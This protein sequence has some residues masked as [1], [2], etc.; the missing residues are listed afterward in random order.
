MFTSKIQSAK[1]R[2]FVS[3]RRADNRALVERIRD[4]LTERYRYDVFLDVLDID[5]GEDWKARI[6]E[7][8][9]SSNVF[10]IMIGEHWLDRVSGGQYRLDSEDDPVAFEIETALARRSEMLIIPILLDGAEI[11]DNKLWPNKLRDVLNFHVMRINGHPEFKGNIEN[12][13]TNI[14][15]HFYSPKPIL[16]IAIG[17]LVIVAIAIIIILLLLSQRTRSIV[18]NFENGI[19]EWKCQLT[20]PTTEA[21]VSVKQSNEYAFG[22]SNSL[23]MMLELIGGSPNQAKG[24]VWREITGEKDYLNLDGRRITAHVYIPVGAM[25]S[26]ESPNGLQIFVKDAEWRN[27]Y[28]CWH[29]IS[30]ENTWIDVELSVSEASNACDGWFTQRGFDPTRIRAYGIKLGSGGES[31]ETYNGAIY[32]DDFTIEQ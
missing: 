10:L 1:P 23:E 11:P 29:G 12:L 7:E 9:N 22:A 28:G 4:N 19:Q 13:A 21:C 2:I 32:L 30:A 18:F 3:Y 27:Q 20:D 25:G 15:K 14:N 8:I 31:T 26:P 24:E 17:L 16:R 5:G 6:R